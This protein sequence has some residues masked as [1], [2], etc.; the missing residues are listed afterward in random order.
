MYL[1]IYLFTYLFIY[2]FCSRVVVM[3]RLTT[4]HSAETKWLLSDSPRWDIPHSLSGSGDIT[5]W[6]WVGMGLKTWN[7]G[8]GEVLSSGM[9]W[10][11]LHSGTLSSC[12]YETHPRTCLSASCHEGGQAHKASP[13]PEDLWSVNHY[14]GRETPESGGGAI[15]ETKAKY[16]LM[17][18]LSK[19]TRLGSVWNVDP[20]TLQV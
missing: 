10:L 20:R 5:E 4:C 8:R 1:F 9:M 17:E 11:F 19:Q 7:W 13:V 16:R 15:W 2:L 12:D 14:W 18:S 6:L 3:Q